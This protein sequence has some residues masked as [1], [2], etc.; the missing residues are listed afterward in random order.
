[1][2]GF[3]RGNGKESQQICFCNKDYSMTQSWVVLLK[4]Q[5][6][7]K[8]RKEGRVDLD[9]STTRQRNNIRKGS[10]VAVMGKGG[11][12]F[13]FWVTARSVVNLLGVIVLFVTFNSI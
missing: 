2:G 4:N 1:M 12:R 13:G 6:E 10:S 9:S 5:N 3:F 8:E 11:P 7:T